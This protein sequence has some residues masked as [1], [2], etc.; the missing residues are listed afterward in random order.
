MFRKTNFVPV[1]ISVLFIGLIFT[2]CQQQKQTEAPKTAEPVAVPQTKPA[3][4]QMPQTATHPPAQIGKGSTDP[5]S[6]ASVPT[7]A[8]LSLQQGMNYLRTHDYDNAIKEF[9]VAIQKYPNYDVAYSNRAVAYMQQS[10]FNKALDDLKKAEEINP[11]NPTV[12][13]NFVAL[14]SLQKQLDR[15][16]D[17]LDRALELGF[18]NYDALRTDTDL[19][20]VRKHP[21]FRKILEKHK[22]FIMK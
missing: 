21:E 1:L 12:H 6:Q 19:N 9:T 22:V 11:N 15:A 2:G 7:E 3:T 18:N 10:K 13:Y 17:S 20:N 16:L 4:E 14:Y 8:K 5:T